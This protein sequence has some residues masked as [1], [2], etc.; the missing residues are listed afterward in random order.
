MDFYKPNSG[1][2]TG[3]EHDQHS[4][5]H[6]APFESLFP[7]KRAHPPNSDIMDY[8]GLLLYF[9]CMESYVRCS[10]E[11]NFFYS[12]IFVRLTPIV[13]F[14]HNEGIANLCSILLCGYTNIHLYIL[15]FIDF[16]IVDSLVN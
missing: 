9:V 15:L 11:I 13:A 16:W 3:R 7:L 10:F 6:H 2:D 8:T 5:S 12:V 1:Q 4:R 14:S